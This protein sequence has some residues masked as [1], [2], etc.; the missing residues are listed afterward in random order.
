MAFTDGSAW[1]FVIIVRQ[2][3]DEPTTHGLLLSE[4]LDIVMN[5]AGVR[6]SL[7]PSD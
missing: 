1:K 5:D 2:S 3:P 6:S 4:T 7:R